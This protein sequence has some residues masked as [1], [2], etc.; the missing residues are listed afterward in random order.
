MPDG[1]IFRDEPVGQA[2]APCRT[3]GKKSA[4]W[5]MACLLKILCKKD[6]DVID[7]ARTTQ[8]IFKIKRIFFE[9]PIFDGKKWTT[10]HFE[11][12][13]TARLK[14]WEKVS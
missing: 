2:V 8:K 6:K 14:I 4:D 13:G 10:K 1:P 7:A 5:D 12:G 11:A 3:G 9:D